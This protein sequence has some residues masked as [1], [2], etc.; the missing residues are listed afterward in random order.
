L[1]Y[2]VASLYQGEESLA[3]TFDR[4]LNNLTEFVG[5][6]EYT[7][8][9]PVNCTETISEKWVRSRDSYHAFVEGVQ[10]L[11]FQWEEVLEI[12]ASPTL[13]IAP[14]SDKLKVLFGEKIT[15]AVKSASRAIAEARE[16]KQLY[17]EKT[18]RTL[19]PVAPA[20]SASAVRSRDHTFFGNHES[21][22]RSEDA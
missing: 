11:R 7:I 16:R 17:V 22:C 15:A 10:H 8:V 20:M 9:N 1:T 2:L 12:A 6:G 4:T 18:S 21:A 13:G 19:L 3:I 14:L 5:S